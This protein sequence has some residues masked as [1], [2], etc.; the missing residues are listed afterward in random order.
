MSSQNPTSAGNALAAREKL[1]QEVLEGRSRAIARLISI[2]EDDPVEAEAYLRGCFPHTGRAFVLGVTGAPGVGKSTLVDRLAE[3]QRAAGARVA[4]IAVDPS[5]PFSGGAILGDRI[6]MQSRSTDPGTFIRSMASRGRLG[7]LAGATGDAV[8][9][10]DAAGFDVVMIETVG[11]GQAE[12]D[13]VRTAHATLLVL[14]PGMG[15][16]IQAMKAGIME[17][18]DV[19]VINK[20]DRPGV[21]RMEAELRTLV[22]MGRRAD[23]WEP[24]VLRTVA[25]ESVGTSACIQAIETYRE[26]RVSSAGSRDRDVQIKKGRILEIVRRLVQHRI[27]EAVGSEGIEDLARRVADHAIDPYSAAEEL[28]GR[29]LRGDRQKGG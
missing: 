22:S 8:N 18:A 17:I 21:E 24:P 27:L 26:F 29:G 9:V 11:V 10:L 16:D 14:V 20:A 5:S 25:S 3:A 23:G 15:D 6:R 13:V 28:L 12:I 2:V 1:L 19:F 7:G 4:I